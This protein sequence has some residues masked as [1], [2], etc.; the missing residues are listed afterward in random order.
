MQKKKR[1]IL[2]EWVRGNKKENP[3]QANWNGWLQRV[4]VKAWS[5]GLLGSFKTSERH[6][7]MPKC[8]WDSMRGSEK[9][10]ACVRALL[11]CM[12]SAKN[13]GRLRDKATWECERKR[14]RQHRREVRIKWEREG[15]GGGGMGRERMG[16]N[17]QAVF[18]RCC[19]LAS[20]LT[21]YLRWESIEAY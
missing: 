17:S 10:I 21:I 1:E 16:N 18:S 11:F 6:F 7:N 13:C 2:E 19:W 15:D 9:E 8:A 4:A 3:K 14:K 12:W 5:S 20:C